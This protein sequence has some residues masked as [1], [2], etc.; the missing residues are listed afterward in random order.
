MCCVQG[1]GAREMKKR[2]RDANH[3][4][5]CRL[6]ATLAARLAQGTARLT[7]CLVLKQT[8]EQLKIA[9]AYG[10]KTNSPM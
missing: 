5:D 7:P 8:K 6:G 10:N 2:P 9:P 4:V 1:T 3:Y